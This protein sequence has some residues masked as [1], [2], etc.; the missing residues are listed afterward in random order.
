MFSCVVEFTV[1]T[2]RK[3]KILHEEDQRDV[4]EF[5]VVIHHFCEDCGQ[6][7][8]DEQ[9]AERSFPLLFHCTSERN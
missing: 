3:R 9:N 5:A 7:I 1:T 6:K 4:Y 2:L 8:Y